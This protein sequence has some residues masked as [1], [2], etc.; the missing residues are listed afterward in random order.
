MYFLIVVD[1]KIAFI[2]Y[3]C[4]LT[5]L[6]CSIKL[7]FGYIENCLLFLFVRAQVNHK[8]CFNYIC[9]YKFEENFVS[10]CSLASYG[11]HSLI[12]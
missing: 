10:D 8:T 12:I 7:N 3:C 5:V 6:I 1:H 4:S 11:I 9:I 2:N